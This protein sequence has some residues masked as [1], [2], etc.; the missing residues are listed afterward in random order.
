[1]PAAS[2]FITADR[3]FAPAN[4]T[5]NDLREC[6]MKGRQADQRPAAR[7]SVTIKGFEPAGNVQTF[8][9]YCGCV[10]RP[11]HSFPAFSQALSANAAR[12]GNAWAAAGCICHE[13]ARSISKV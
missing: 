3:Q 10:Q 4:I 7:L 1:M 8:T 5:A 12:P 6:W 9:E 11:F 2:L 13:V